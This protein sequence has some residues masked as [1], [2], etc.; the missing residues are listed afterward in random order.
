MEWKVITGPTA[1]P[2]DHADVK[3][4]LGIADSITSFDDLIDSMIIVAREWLEKRTALSV[5]SKAYKAYFEEDDC[6]DGWYELPFSPVLATPAITVSVLGVSTTFQQRGLNTVYIYPDSVYATIPP[7]TS[8]Q[9]YYVEVLFTAGE[10][11]NTANECIKRIAASIFN[12]RDD[13]VGMNIARL[14]F[15]TVKLIDS[16]SLNL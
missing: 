3:D 12:H 11:N 5:V 10:A 15:D 16:I 2:V 13:G 7:G 6:E 8:A 9:P 1:E 14:P 4:L